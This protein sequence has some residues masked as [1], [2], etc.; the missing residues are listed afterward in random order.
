MKLTKQQIK[1]IIKE[2]M[3]QIIKEETSSTVD[4]TNRGSIGYKHQRSREPGKM[5]T[6]SVALPEPKV[7]AS[8]ITPPSAAWLQSMIDLY[9]KVGMPEAAA[10]M[11]KELDKM[12]GQS[13]EEL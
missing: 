3:N 2:E 5:N 12:S 10:V 1:E 4:E 11:Q 7:D 6:A 9:M 8:A 13:M